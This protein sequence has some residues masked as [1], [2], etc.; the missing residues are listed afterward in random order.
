MA[1]GGFHPFSKLMSFC[2]QKPQANQMKALSEG[3]GK[4]KMSLLLAKENK[5]HMDR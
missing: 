4:E 5:I 3:K 1:R 2:N